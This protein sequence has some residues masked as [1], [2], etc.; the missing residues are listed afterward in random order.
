MK[1]LKSNILLLGV[2]IL[3]LVSSGFAQM[4]NERD[5]RMGMS[6]RHLPILSKAEELGLND[7]QVTDLKN[8]HHDFLKKSIEIE[9]KLKILELD[10]KKS[11]TDDAT[12]KALNKQAD[13]IASKMAEKRK[14]HISMHFKVRNTLTIEQWD[15]WKKSMHGS[16]MK[17]KMM[18]KRKEHMKSKEM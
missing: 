17:K 5:G 7:K 16:M 12:E 15:K 11:M 8:I 3:L 13:N 10:F 2:L 4:H 14:L 6:G 9:S 1:N 18:K